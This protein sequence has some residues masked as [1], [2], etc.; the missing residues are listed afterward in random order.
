MAELN[1]EEYVQ[2]LDEQIK[3]HGT[4]LEKH[5]NAREVLLRSIT[6]ERTVIQRELAKGKRGPIKHTQPDRGT[7][8]DVRTRVLEALQDNPPAKLEAGDFIRTILGDRPYHKPER[9]RI[10]GVLKELR[11]KKMVLLNKD[12]TYSLP[13]VNYE[14][15]AVA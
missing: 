14:E 5:M 13:P 6:A 15:A 7:W 12:H 4:E 11:D 2:Y 3:F 10:Y 1:V 9:D 8:A